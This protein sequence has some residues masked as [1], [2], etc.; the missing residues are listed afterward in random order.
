MFFTRDTIISLSVSQYVCCVVDGCCCC[1]FVRHCFFFLQDRGM[2]Y[3][4]V[5]SLFN[6]ASPRLSVTHI[7]CFVYTFIS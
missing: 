6:R 3:M 2:Y 5:I 4:S 1:V 7:I